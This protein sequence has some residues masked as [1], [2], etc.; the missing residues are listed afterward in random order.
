MEWKPGVILQLHHYSCKMNN[1][2]LPI[3]SSPKVRYYGFSIRWNCTNNYFTIR[4]EQ[5]SSTELELRD[6]C[7]SDDVLYNNENIITC[8]SLDVRKSNGVELF[9]T[10]SEDGK[11]I[12]KPPNKLFRTRAPANQAKQTKDQ[13]FSHIDKVS[14]SVPSSIVESLPLF[15]MTLPVES[16]SD[17]I[18]TSISENKDACSTQSTTA[19]AATLPIATEPE[20]LLSP[21]KLCQ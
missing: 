17:A 1:I 9:S 14:Q 4:T 10:T 13:V 12:F 6:I 15:R 19:T 2:N 21:A 20:L 18:I 8:S 7:D 11:D 3:L 16:T 5:K